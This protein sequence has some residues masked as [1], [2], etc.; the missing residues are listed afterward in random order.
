MRY[1][2]TFIAATLLTAS[3]ASNAAQTIEDDK[4]VPINPELDAKEISGTYLIDFEGKSYTGHIDQ[5]GVQMGYPFQIYKLEKSGDTTSL[6]I[7]ESSRPLTKANPDD[8]C[9]I[10]IQKEYNGYC[11]HI[12]K[13]V[14]KSNN[15]FD[16]IDRGRTL[17]ATR[18]Q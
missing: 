18:T 14:A 7:T 4:F 17:T 16:F 1:F 2:K 12:L 3:F 9:K 15:K 13:V 10:A 11:F 6:F 5:Y 8:T